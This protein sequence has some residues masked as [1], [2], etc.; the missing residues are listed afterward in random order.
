MPWLRTNASGTSVPESVI[1][2]VFWPRTF[3]APYESLIILE[4]G[5]RRRPLL[6]QASE[7][8]TKETE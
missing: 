4:G 1:M 6:M 5:L 7:F 2:A 3:H 8:P